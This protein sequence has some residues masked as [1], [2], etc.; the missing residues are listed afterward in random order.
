MRLRLVVVE[1]N[2]DRNGNLKPDMFTAGSKKKV[3]W[4]CEKGHEW[5]TSI[6]NRTIGTRCPICSNAKVLEGYN[7]LAT[8]NPKLA[9]EWNYEKNND[10]M[11][12]MFTANSGKQVWWKCD[13]GHEWNAEIRARNR[14]AKCPICKT[15]E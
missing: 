10:L 14:G 5:Q 9:K 2:N 12:T 3:W 7:D 13:K 6:H 15:K 1:W 11:T 4:K 8:A